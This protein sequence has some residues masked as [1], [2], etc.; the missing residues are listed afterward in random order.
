MGGNNGVLTDGGGTVWLTTTS[1]I[2]PGEDMTIEFVIF[3]VGD[4]AWDSLVLL[5]NFKWS[6][7]PASVGTIGGQ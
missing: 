7:T 6:L 1:P 4:H 5:D 3:D 2:K